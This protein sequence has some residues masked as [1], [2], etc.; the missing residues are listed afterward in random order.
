M[1]LALFTVMIILPAFQVVGAF[2][3]LCHRT[4]FGGVNLEC[5]FKGYTGFKPDPD[6]YCQYTCTGRGTDDE[7]YSLPEGI[8]KDGHVICDANGI[9]KLKKWKNGLDKRKNMICE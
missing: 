4:Y 8:C 7:K 1:L 6:P 5:K 2:P 9:L 3:D